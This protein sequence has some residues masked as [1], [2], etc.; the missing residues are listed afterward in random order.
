MTAAPSEGTRERGGT[1]TAWHVFV[2]LIALASLSPFV[3]AP[4]M[5]EFVPKNSSVLHLYAIV[6]FIGANFHV[7]ASGWFYTDRQMWP[8]LSDHPL[9]YFIVPA[10]LIPASAA[11]FWLVDRHVA[12]W[13][14]L[15][16]L[17]WQIWH[18]QK[19]NVGLLSFIA[20]GTDKVPLSPWERRALLLAGVAGILG[21]F[22]VVRLPPEN[23]HPLF[24]TLHRIGM[25][26]YLLTVAAAIVAFLFQPGLRRNPL[27]LAFFLLGVLFFA[28]T[29]LFSDVASAIGG[30]AL[31]HGLQ[32]LVFMGFICAHKVS[33]RR[34]VIILLTL[35]IGGGFLLNIGSDAAAWTEG[36]GMALFGA[37]VGTVMS[38]FVLDAGVWRLR[39]PFQRAYMREH[40]NFLFQRPSQQ[41]QQQ[42]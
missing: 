1:V 11:T 28:P 42:S 2:V 18:Y 26:V 3:T 32:Y 23:L 7:A 27:R 6:G 16:F 36:Y 17:A 5:A 14:V 35:G 22:N 19:Q 34:A 24:A 10:V 9:R 37:F 29:F 15:P 21:F 20:S 4:V 33:A 30:Y 41:G 13:L 38:H 25:G 12:Y 39:E 40:F 31:A 8:H